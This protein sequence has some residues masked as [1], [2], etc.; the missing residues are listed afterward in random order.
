[1]LH[2]V[3]RNTNTAA[4]QMTSH[5]VLAATD[6][7]EKILGAITHSRG[8]EGCPQTG[9]GSS[10]SPWP[11]YYML[12]LTSHAHTHFLT[13]SCVTSYSTIIS[14]PCPPYLLKPQIMQIH[15]PICLSVLRSK[16]IFEHPFCTQRGF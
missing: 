3:A 13:V 15:T 11:F 9:E 4:H 7:N 2:T 14:F 10:Y 6:R 5:M 1:M 8:L 16:R 12:G